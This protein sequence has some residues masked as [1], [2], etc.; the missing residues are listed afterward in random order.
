MKPGHRRAQGRP[1]R[2]FRAVLREG[3]YSAP[4][5]TEPGKPRSYRPSLLRFK[6]A[7][8][9]RLEGW[10][11]TV[12]LEGQYPLGIPRLDKLW[13][14]PLCGLSVRTYTKDTLL[15]PSDPWAPPCLCSRSAPAQLRVVP[16]T[17]PGWTDAAHRGSPWGYWSIRWI[18][19]N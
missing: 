9:L 18:P 10:T 7:T 11:A 8:P 2:C 12:V 3:R 1:C 13:Y 5:F 15:S 14:L 19:T 6:A 4:L 17:Y 16:R